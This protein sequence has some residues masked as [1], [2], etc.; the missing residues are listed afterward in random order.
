MDRAAV[1]SFVGIRNLA[2]VC[3]LLGAVVTGAAGQ[4]PSTTPALPPLSWTCPMHPDVVESEKGACRICGMAL[5]PI[6][7]DIAWSCPIHTDIILDK[8]GRCPLCYR[9]LVQVVVALSWTCPKHPNVNVASPGVCPIDKTTPLEIRRTIRA[10][11]DHNPKHGGLFF[12]A[13]D[14]RHHLE[15]T[16]PSAEVYR[17]YTYDIFTKPYVPKTLEGRVYLREAADSPLSKEKT[18]YPLRL[19][20]NG[21]YFEARVPG[22]PLPSAIF[23]L[24]RL[25]PKGEEY[26]FD[27]VF[28]AYTKEPS[29]GPR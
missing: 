8:A 26:R 17:F 21:R 18:S 29:T 15:A 12:M 1:V 2:V 11:G 22:Q 7:L 23:L 5:V 19:A 20:P 10:H 24:V 3:V 28:P 16:H 14:N 25:E 9:D 6:R 27:F 13:A 4:A